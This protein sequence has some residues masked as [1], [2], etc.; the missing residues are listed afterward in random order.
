MKSRIQLTSGDLS[1]EIELTD[2]MISREILNLLPVHSQANIWGKEVYFSIPMGIVQ[3]NNPRVN[4]ENGDIGYYPPLK[5]ICIFFGPTPV[6]TD[7][8]PRAAAPVSLIGKISGKMEDLSE[9][10]QGDSV[11]LKIHM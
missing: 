6:S 9:I 11:T 1:F 8:K 7:N 3:E 10:K 4:M 2:C 5:A